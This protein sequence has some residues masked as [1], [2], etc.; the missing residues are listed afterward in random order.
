MGYDNDDLGIASGRSLA[1]FLVAISSFMTLSHVF[2]Y[3]YR[4]KYVVAQRW[5]SIYLM[6]PLVVGWIAWAQLIIG[7]PTIYLEFLRNMFKGMACLSFAMYLIRVIGWENDSFRFEYRKERMVL[8][9]QELRTINRT[10][11]CLGT[12]TLNTRFEVEKFIGIMLRNVIQYLVV[13]NIC[14]F[15]SL[16]C[17]LA[18]GFSIDTDIDSSRPIA[19]LCVQVFKGISNVTAIATLR[20]LSKNASRISEL[21]FI[22]ISG[23]CKTAILSIMLLQFQPNFVTLLAR[24]GYLGNLDDYT[25]KEISLWTNSMLFCID[26]V[27]LASIIRWVFPLTDYDKAPSDRESLVKEENLTVF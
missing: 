7:E 23:K 9:F 20:M 14:F 22:N 5:I 13:I 6:Y 11:K 12:Y 4:A 8:K 2:P 17:Y 16:I 21:R 10:F 19:Y 26:S 15:A 27:I 18:Y 1:L 25:L 24:T 3:L